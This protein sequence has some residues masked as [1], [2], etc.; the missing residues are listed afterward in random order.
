VVP[1]S[2]IFRSEEAGDY[3]LVAGNDNKAHQKKVQV[4]IRNKD[5]AQVVS[6]IDAGEAVITSGG[7][8]V[9][10]GTQ[11]KIEAPEKGESAS[12]A[13]EGKSKRGDADE[14][15]G[16]KQGQPDS[17]AGKTAKGKE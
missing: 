16:N 10:D 1:A 15:G 2:A 14:K 5:T 8:G 12:G 9:P 3:V 4:G 6:G 11:I 13:D 17:A 7:Y